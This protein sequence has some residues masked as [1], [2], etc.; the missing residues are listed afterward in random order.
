[1][2]PLAAI[3]AGLLFAGLP[4]GIAFVTHLQASALAP[5][6]VAGFYACEGTNP[7]GTTYQATLEIQPLTHV[8][9]IRWEFENGAE[10]FGIGL[11]RQ[12]RLVVATAFGLRPVLAIYERKGKNLAGVWGGAGVDRLFPESCRPGAPA[13]VR[14]SHTV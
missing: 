3:L 11:I 8:I 6:D 14:P 9:A 10:L 13:P 12:D 2:K 4:F 5:K 1:M 7:E